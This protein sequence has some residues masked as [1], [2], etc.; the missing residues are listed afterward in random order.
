MTNK[1]TPVAATFP[2]NTFAEACATDPLVVEFDA[3]LA[4]QSASLLMAEDRHR[5]ASEARDALHSRLSVVE[6]RCSSRDQA[7]A[8]KIAVHR[9]AGDAAI[10]EGDDDKAAQE[11][12]KAAAIES[13]GPGADLDARTDE[14]QRSSLRAALATAEEEQESAAGTLSQIKTDLAALKEERGWTILDL[15]SDAFVGFV[16][17]MPPLPLYAHKSFCVPLGVSRTYREA[18]GNRS[19]L[20]TQA[21][22]FDL[23]RR[24][25]QR[26]ASKESVSV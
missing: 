20:C 6:A 21:D 13:T 24:R 22:C 12:G 16:A 26:R 9:A 8:Q 7:R 5:A 10:R 3:R 18:R 17:N 2:L 19:G 1:K 11:F 4:T 25:L 23:D 15:V 14:M